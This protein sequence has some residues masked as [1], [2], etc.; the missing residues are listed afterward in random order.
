MP[1]VTITETAFVE[2][3]M[4]NKQQSLLYYNFRHLFEHLGSYLPITKL[5]TPDEYLNTENE[6]TACELINYEDIVAIK[7][8]IKPSVPTKNVA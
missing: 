5:I 2:S 1:P 8:I 7:T 4:Q 6:M 3:I